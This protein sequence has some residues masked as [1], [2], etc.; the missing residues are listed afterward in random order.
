V[1]WYDQIDRGVDWPIETSRGAT[2]A[3][4]A[5]IGHESFVGNG[6]DHLAGAPIRPPSR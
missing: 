2:R 3:F 1:I 5:A 6:F 4:R